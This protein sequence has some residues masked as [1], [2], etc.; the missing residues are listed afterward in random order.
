M[1]DSRSERCKNN[2]REMIR[3]SECVFV[4]GVAGDSGSGKTTFTR[5]IK[6]IFGEEMVSTISLD[7]YHTLDRE[8]RARTG[9]TP[10]S[11]KAN[12]LSLLEEH[13]G[14]LK[15]GLSVQKPVY[16]HETGKI[17][18]P[19]E[20]RPSRI[21]VLEG[22][23]TFSTERLREL[24]DFSIFVNPEREVKYAWKIERDVESRGYR[25]ED[26][27]EELEARRADYE[28]F[29]MPQRKYA[30]AVIGISKSRYG[31]QIRNGRGIYR[32]ILYQKKQDRT[33]RNINLNFD[34]FAINSLSGRS[35]CFGFDVVE[36]YGREMGALSLDGEF[37]REVVR[38]LEENIEIQT[39]VGPV[40]V[41][42]D[43]EYVTATEMVELLLSWR[44]INKRISMEYGE[45]CNPS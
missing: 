22:L 10:L 45:G 32:V 37:R 2:F 7:D 13:V 38:L 6:S 34:L 24:I 21:I 11:P 18:G 41:Y 17:E 4:I 29:V 23:H 42:S 27:L 30:D 3:A 28:S 39:G 25:E 8:D 44:I 31:H 16:N 40:S 20:F 33:V 36:K 14:L 12:D 43:R 26:V 19:V 9:I 5:A 15:R 1:M 35:F